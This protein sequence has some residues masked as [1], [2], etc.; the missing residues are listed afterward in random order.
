MEISAAVW[1]L[2]LQDLTF[3]VGLLNIEYLAVGV[4]I[5]RLCQ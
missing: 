3:Y 5:C 1:A 2:W 4:L